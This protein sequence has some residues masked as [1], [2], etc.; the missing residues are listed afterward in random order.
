M[1]WKTIFIMAL[2]QDYVTPSPNKKHDHPSHL[3]DITDAYS[4]NGTLLLRQHEKELFWA[5]T[6]IHK[7]PRRWWIALTK[8]QGS[9]TMV[10]ILG[11]PAVMD[12]PGDPFQN[13]RQTT[14]SGKSIKEGIL[15]L[16]RVGGSR[17]KY[18][19]YRNLSN[20]CMCF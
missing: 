11:Y 12:L 4:I 15:V 2:L 20:T 1:G 17:R 14:E 16:G 10:M 19:T 13:K 6:I 3:M 7:C 18:C 5:I 8:I 9:A